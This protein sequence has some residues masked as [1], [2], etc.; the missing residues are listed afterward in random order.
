MYA[1][2]GVALP[3]ELDTAE[4]ACPVCGQLHCVCPEDETDAD[5]GVCICGAYGIAGGTHYAKPSPDEPVEE[6]GRFL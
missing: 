4:W 3:T 5:V 1:A 6:C 2:Q